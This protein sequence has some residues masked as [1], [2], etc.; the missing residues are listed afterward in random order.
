MNF[1]GIGFL[2]CAASILLLLPASEKFLLF[3]F[4]LFW[5]ITALST[6]HLAKGPVGVSIWPAL[7]GEAAS[8]GNSVHARCFLE[9]ELFV[10]FH[11]ILL[12]AR[13]QLGA[14]SE[15][16]FVG[17]VGLFDVHF[18][19]K[20][21]CCRIFSWTKISGWPWAV[22]ALWR[23]VSL[24]Q[25]FGCGT[26]TSAEALVFARTRARVL[27]P[28]WSGEQSGTPTAA[29]GVARFWPRALPHLRQLSRPWE[30][31]LVLFLR[32]ATFY[33]TLMCPWMAFLRSCGQACVLYP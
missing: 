2:L 29:S 30:A 25:H 18:S 7:G 27:V 33:V 14:F 6:D 12:G 16:F 10:L 13:L 9:T 32:L 20:L 21:L 23:P 22:G 24:E 3:F 17:V 4:L 28:P 1:F 26:C 5:E 8:R 15:L 31:Y 11:G 19:G